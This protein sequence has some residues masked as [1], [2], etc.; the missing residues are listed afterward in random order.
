MLANMTFVG[1]GGILP[2]VSC[3]VPRIFVCKKKAPCIHAF[4]PEITS[5]E[6]DGSRSHLTT[7]YYMCSLFAV[8]KP[9]NEKVAYREKHSQ[10]KFV[11]SV[12]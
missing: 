11:S 9:P 4:G 6:K 5:V 7:N 2:M 1:R 8:I 12:K 10:K 3:T